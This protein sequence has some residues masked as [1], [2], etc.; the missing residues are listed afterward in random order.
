M[1]KGMV[2]IG[3]KCGD[4]RVKLLGIIGFSIANLSRLRLFYETCGNNTKL[5][6]PVREIN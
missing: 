6:P 5:A 1:G 4:Y 3:D 2:K